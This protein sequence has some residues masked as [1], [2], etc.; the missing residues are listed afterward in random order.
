MADN[1]PVIRLLSE[2]EKD[3]LGELIEGDD[4]LAWDL[5]VEYMRLVHKV[6]ADPTA[7]NVENLSLLLDG[8]VRLVIAPDRNSSD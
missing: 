7:K 5:F 3:R 1:R 8:P 6:L 4:E 2:A